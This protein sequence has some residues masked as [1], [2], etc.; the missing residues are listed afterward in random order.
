M[1]RSTMQ[2]RTRSDLVRRSRLRTRSSLRTFNVPRWGMHVG[3]LLP[4]QRA[5]PLLSDAHLSRRDLLQRHARWRHP[6]RDLPVQ[7]MTRCAILGV[8]C[9]AASVCCDG[10]IDD[11]I[12]SSVQDASDAPSCLASPFGCYDGPYQDV[13]TFDGNLG[14]VFFDG[15]TECG[16]PKQ[17]CGAG[18]VDYSCCNGTLC[19]GVCVLFDDASSPDCF[20]YGL[21]GG[22]PSPQVCCAASGAFPIPTKCPSEGPPPP[23]P[24]PDAGP[25]C[26]D[27]G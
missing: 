10:A 1:G 14:F 11:Q 23:P 26:P 4:A 2:P 18:R 27:G 3:R 7:P 17:P 9:L 24:P 12:D 25:L 5:L 21:D 19:E 13:P 20:C 16:I 15:G 8:G 6:L 22:C